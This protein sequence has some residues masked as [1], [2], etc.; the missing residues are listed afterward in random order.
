[1]AMGNGRAR[2]VLILAGS[3]FGWIGCG[4]NTAGNG[5]NAGQ[6]GDA[7]RDASIADGSAGAADAP[8]GNPADHAVGT[9]LD[10]P[11][12]T[13]SPA[14]VATCAPQSTSPLTPRK[15]A[16][17]GFSGT[18]TDYSNLYNVTCATPADC[19]GP[20]V[21]AGGTSASCTAGSDCVAEGFDGGMQCL[22][23]TYWL[24]V[25][26]ALSES[27][28]T[29]N[30]AALV[31]VQTSYDDAL[32]VTDFGIPVPDGA[33][34]QGVQFSVRR[35]ATSGLAV[36]ESVQ[37]LKNGAPVGLEHRL[38]GAWPTTLTYATYGG[39]TD[40]W[41]VSWTAAD[42]RAAG[43]GLSIAPRY[44]SSFGNERAYVDSVRAVV[45]FTPAC[46]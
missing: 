32:V 13:D 15:A 20:C 7:G 5:A 46:H 37:I 39:P 41:G 12:A 38:T 43:F 9:D 26:G 2:G 33:T 21:T 24:N 10:A 27:G 28:T 22:P 1:M 16:S 11:S 35:E 45:F 29:D 4:G 36:D 40:T 19:V 23:P 31:L 17:S 6:D 3:I 44:T 14:D 25:A 34:I 42:I 30:A 8:G 18:D